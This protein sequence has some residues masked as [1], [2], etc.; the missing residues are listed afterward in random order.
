[1]L[2]R[3][4]DKM[5]LIPFEEFVFTATKDGNIVCDKDIITRPSE[6]KSRVIAEYSTND[7]ALNVLDMMCS[8]YERFSGGNTYTDSVFQ[9]PQESEV[10]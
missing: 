2:I 8:A 3:S 6:L 1:M 5:Q 4:Q 10:E 7:K 9:M